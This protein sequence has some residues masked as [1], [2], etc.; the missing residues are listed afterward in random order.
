[1]AWMIRVH[2]VGARV[3]KGDGIT[4]NIGMGMTVGIAII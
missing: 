4:S 3:C 2:D 1:M